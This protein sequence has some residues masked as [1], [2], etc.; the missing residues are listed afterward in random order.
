MAASIAASATGAWAGA[1]GRLRT[2]SIRW[3]SDTPSQ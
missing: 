1:S 3:N 2:C